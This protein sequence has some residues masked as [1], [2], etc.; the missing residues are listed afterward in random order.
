MSICV[1]LVCSWLCLPLGLAATGPP[2][3]RMARKQLKQSAV[4]DE[5]LTVQA[6]LTV[7]NVFLYAVVCADLSN[8]LYMCFHMK[9]QLL[10]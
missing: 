8:S 1:C 5:H 10:C 2:Q 9:Q 6:T 7:I 3:N 4:T